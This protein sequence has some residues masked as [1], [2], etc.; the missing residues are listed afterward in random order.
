M[1][2]TCYS[3]AISGVNALPVEIE[4]NS[5]RGSE[6]FAIVGLP[7]AAV[8]EAKDRVTT[9]IENS[10]FNFKEELDITVNLAP[11]DLRK[12]GPIYDLPLRC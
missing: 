1:L 4:V 10:G 7:D 2:A 11:A 9:A 8:K 6:A 5:Y 3:G 12:E